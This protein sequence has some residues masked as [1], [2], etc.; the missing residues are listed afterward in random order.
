VEAS[1][2]PVVQNDIQHSLTL[3]THEAT[4]IADLH[5]NTVPDQ[6]VLVA[7][8]VY[9]VAAAAHLFLHSLL[10]SFV[11][12]DSYSDAAVLVGE[13]GESSETMTSV[14]GTSAYP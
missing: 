8:I 6:P 13:S 4:C 1:G 11:V 7:C 3:L 10:S 12:F 14:P 5:F 9:R 2:A